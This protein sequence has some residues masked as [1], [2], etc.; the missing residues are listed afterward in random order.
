MFSKAL[1]TAD[2]DN[3]LVISSAWERFERCN[4]NLKT[5]NN[6]LKECNIFKQSYRENTYSNHKQQKASTAKGTKRKSTSQQENNAPPPKQTKVSDEVHQQKEKLKTGYVKRENQMAFKEHEN[7]EI[8]LSKDHLRIFLSNLDYNLSEEEVQSALPELN[9]VKM[10]LIRS[11][12]GRSRGFGYA[13]L[14]SEV[15]MKF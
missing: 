3:P 2:I 9:I 5:L 11:G 10:E 8:D 14:A 7:Q 1:H 15:G 12:N 6:C 13:E 4:G